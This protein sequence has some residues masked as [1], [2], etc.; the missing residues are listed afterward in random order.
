[1]K[2]EVWSYDDHRSSGVV[3]A[4]PQKILAESTLLALQH[5]REALQRSVSRP[6][7]WTAT[8][9][10]IE[11]SVD[12]LLEHSL[13]VIDDDLRSSEIQQSLETVIT[14]DHTPIEIVQ[15]RGGESTAV[16]LHH[17]SKIRWNDWNKVQDHRTRIVNT[18]TVL[19]PRV[20]GGHDLESLDSLLATL[21]GEWSLCLD[22]LDHLAKLDFFLVK[23]DSLN[24]S[25]NGLGTHASFKVLAV[26]IFE[27]TPKKLIFDNHPGVKVAK[28]VKSTSEEFNT[29]V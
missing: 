18:L 14:V 1:M 11:E 22:R 19:I 15:V 23:I 12:R 7:N 9:T 3:H 24:E 25:R 16:E 13:F 5:V 2:L 20:K 4:L 10:I 8:P 26:A 6:R 17:R 21:C 27:L 29:T 28:L